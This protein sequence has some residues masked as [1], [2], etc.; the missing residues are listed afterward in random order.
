[1]AENPQFV[2]LTGFAFLKANKHYSG[3]YK[4]LQ[5]SVDIIEG[6]A[7]KQIEAAVWPAPYC[8]EAT[9]PALVETALFALDEDGMHSAERWI[10][11]RYSDEKERWKAAAEVTVLDALPWQPPKEPL[12]E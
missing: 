11:S 6:E 3:S 12:A 1:M 10:E 7:G 4:G 2:K 8:R 9:D 5:Y